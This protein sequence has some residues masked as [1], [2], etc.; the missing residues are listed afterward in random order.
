MRKW[1]GSCFCLS[2]GLTHPHLQGELCHSESSVPPAIVTGSGMG[3]LGQSAPV[4]GY[5]A[6]PFGW[7]LGSLELLRHLRIRV[8]E[9]KP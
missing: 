5:L 1:A 3:K 4:L 9:N 7:G 2:K 8:E 6:L